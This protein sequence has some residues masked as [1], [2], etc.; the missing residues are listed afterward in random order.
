MLHY[1]TLGMNYFET[2]SCRR[3]HLIIAHN[4][5]SSYSK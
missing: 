4:Q 5:A 2:Q 1:E 3:A